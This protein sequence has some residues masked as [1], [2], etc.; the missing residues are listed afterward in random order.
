[1][2][3]SAHT[4]I[5]QPHNGRTA[6]LNA[7]NSAKASIDLTIY[8]IS[9]SQIMSALQ[10]AQKRGVP[11]RVLYNWYSFDTDTQQREILPA[12]D[13]LTSAGIACKQAPKTFEVTHEKS[14]VIDATT[15]IVMSFNLTSEYFGTT[16]DFGIIT[17]VPSEVNEIANVF[18]ADW[19]S[20]S[21]TPTVPSLV[22][23]PTNSRSKL[24]S[25]IG[26]AQKTLDIYNEEADDPGT[27]HAIIAAA[28]RGV[29]VRFI[30]AVLTTDSKVNENARGVTLMQA[31]GVSAVCKSFLYIHAKMLLVDYGNPNSQAFV[32]SQNF[33]CVSLDDNRECGILVTESAILDRL[34][35]V[36]QSDWPQPNVTVAPDNTPIKPCMGNPAARA[37]LRSQLRP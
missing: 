18:E 35:S 14:F 4:L 30:A 36:Y 31:G 8:E 9:D 20:Q 32:G 13:Q 19:N 5:V 17:T 24:A 28:N 16:R 3:S 10:S 27:L 29:A 23:S 1:M 21:I 37:Q 12:I 7:L 2:T 33:S 34:H 6:V 25:L 15:A 26:S 11:V 22:W